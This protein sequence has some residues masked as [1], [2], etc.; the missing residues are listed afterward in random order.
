MEDLI[1]EHLYFLQARLAELTHHMG[2]TLRKDFSNSVTHLVANCAGGEKY[3][4]CAL[5]GDC[6]TWDIDSI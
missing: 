4:V 5:F 3:R 2:G 6:A 1:V